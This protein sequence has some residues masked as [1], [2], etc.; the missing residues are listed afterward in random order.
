MTPDSKQGACQ[1]RKLT[2]KEVQEED[3]FACSSEGED[4]A[5]S[6]AHTHGRR[7]KCQGA[8]G[9]D[10]RYRALVARANF[11]SSDRPDISHAVKELCRSISAPGSTDWDALK[12]L[13]TSLIGKPR[14][15]WYFKWQKRP[16]QI[17]VLTDSDWAG[18]VKTRKSASGGVL[19]RG[20]I[21][22][23]IG[24]APIPQ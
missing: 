24:Q 21:L 14:L 1:G 16:S 5:A 23:S 17:H 20:S 13:G 3:T 8:G 9:E 11:L 10:T 18:C 2:Q 4:R 6:F 7:D 22:S 12:R 19:F 15:V